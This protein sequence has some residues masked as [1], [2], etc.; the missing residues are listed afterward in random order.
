MTASISRIALVLAVV[1]LGLPLMASAALQTFASIQDQTTP[2]PT[3]TLINEGTRLDQTVLGSGYAVVGNIVSFFKW[4][5]D[6]VITPVWC[7][8]L[9]ATNNITSSIFHYQIKLCR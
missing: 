7:G 4:M 8:T 3:P 6:N 1:M 5:S 2:S 9:V